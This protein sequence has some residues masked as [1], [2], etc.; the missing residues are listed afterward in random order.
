MKQSSQSWLFESSRENTL[1]FRPHPKPM[2]PKWN[3]WKLADNSNRNPKMRTTDLP[4]LL[5]YWKVSLCACPTGS[6]FSLYQLTH[7]RE[8]FPLTD[9]CLFA[10][11]QIGNTQVWWTMWAIENVN[12]TWLLSSFHKDLL[13]PTERLGKDLRQGALFPGERNKLRQH[14]WIFMKQCISTY[15]PKCMVGIEMVVGV[16]RKGCVMQG[17]RSCAGPPRMRRIWRGRG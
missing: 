10:W 16:Q 17:G 8:L 4:N 6:K 12:I 2:K 11:S 9:I 5:S 7:V 15:M 14:M 13:S 3:F 1:V